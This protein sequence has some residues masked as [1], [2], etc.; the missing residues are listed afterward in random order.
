MMNEILGSNATDDLWHQVRPVIDDAMHELDEED[1]AVVVLR[2]FEGK[3]FKDVGA[4]FGLSEN[5]ARMRCER[6]LER[7]RGVLSR[8]RLWELDSFVP[9]HVQELIRSHRAGGKDLGMRLWCL[10]SLAAWY[11][12]WIGGGPRPS[13]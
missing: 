12:D 8:S 10:V 5:A 2:F 11:D 3:S 4:A 6:S 1:R 13:A 7:L 9:D